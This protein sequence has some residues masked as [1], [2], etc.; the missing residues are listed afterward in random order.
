M[1]E[2]EPPA[3]VARR[4]RWDSQG[5]GETASAAAAANG[6]AAAALSAAA[7]LSNSVAAAK[8]LAKE[9]L[10]K[11]QRAAEM[12]R[13]IQAQMGNLVGAPLGQPAAPKVPTI[14]LDAQGRLLD[15]RGKVI[16]ST[17]KPTATVKINQTSRVNPLLQEAAAPDPTTSSFY[18]PRMALPG[19]A[20]DQRRKRAFNFVAEGHFSRKADDIRQKAAV[21]QMLR[22]AQQSSKKAAKEAPAESSSVAAWTPQISTASLERRLAEIPVVEW[23]DAPLL[24]ER[25]Y[26]AGGENIMANVVAEA[27]THYVEHPVPIEPPS[28]PPPPPPMP[29][30]LTKKERKKLRTQRRLA[31][32]KEKQDQIRCGLID[33]PPPKVKLSNLM[34]AMK[35][36]AVADPSAIEHRVRAEMAQRIKNHEMR[37]QARELPP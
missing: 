16:Q 13:V 14:T 28:E 36:E 10:A 32:E 11:A 9:A 3:K 21:E 12:Q 31:A 33:P 18:D 26:A 25:S 7:P 2:E 22:E 24:K 15:E 29:L 6:A 37:N 30:P 19:Q 5:E 23:W 17:A 27:V 8:E 20:R 4:N 34:Q 1:A 35:N